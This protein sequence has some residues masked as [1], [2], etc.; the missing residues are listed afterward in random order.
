VDVENFKRLGIVVEKETSTM[1]KNIKEASKGDIYTFNGCSCNL[2]YEIDNN[3][4][5]F[6]YDFITRQ[7]EFIHN[8]E[9]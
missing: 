5:T 7:L 1:L 3:P 8:E 6:D 4:I 2:R 9:R